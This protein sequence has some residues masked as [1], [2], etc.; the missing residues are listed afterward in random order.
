MYARQITSEN[1]MLLQEARQIISAD[2]KRKADAFTS[3]VKKIAKVSI[4]ILAS[5]LTPVILDGDCTALFIF[6]PAAIYFTTER[7]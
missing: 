7:V 2:R 4:C 6:V 5:I 3:K 1:T